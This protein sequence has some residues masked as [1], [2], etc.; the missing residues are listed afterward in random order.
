MSAK[1][2]YMKDSHVLAFSSGE[3]LSADGEEAPSASPPTGKGPN[4]LPTDEQQ[5]TTGRPA[6]APAIAGRAPPKTSAASTLRNDSFRVLLSPL[7]SLLASFLFF[8]CGLWNQKL[9]LGLM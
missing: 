2:N 8:Y 7:L 4:P 5:H 6:V 9:G 3:D 1:I